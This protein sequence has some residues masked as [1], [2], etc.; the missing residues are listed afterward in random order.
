MLGIEAGLGFGGG[1]RIG[2]R[3]QLGLGPRRFQVPNPQQG[4]GL[5]KGL[6]EG[7]RDGAANDPFLAALATHFDLP[8]VEEASGILSGSC[9][10]ACETSW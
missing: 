9:S 4:S 10:W 1:S 6:I 5:P 7:T 8:L 2:V 3:L